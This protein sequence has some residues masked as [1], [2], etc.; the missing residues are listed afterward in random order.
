MKFREEVVNIR[1]SDVLKEIGFKAAGET[2]SKGKLPDVIVYVSGVKINI[3]GRFETSSDV[4]KLKNRCIERVEDGIS[5]IALGIIYPVELKEAENDAELI[6]K[7]KKSEFQ[8]FA[9]YLSSGG[10]KEL[11]F[12]V[13]KIED[14]ARNLNSLYTVIVRNDILREQIKILNSTIKENSELAMESDLFFSSNMV[15][16]K[17]KKVLGMKEEYGKKKED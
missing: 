5:D 10:I 9:I 17:L 6:K 2:I 3:E 13:Q 16:G 12:G 8:S 11:A 14:I 15:V 1:L 7:I 4:S